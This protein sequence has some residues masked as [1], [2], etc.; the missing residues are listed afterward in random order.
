MPGPEHEPNALPPELA[1]F[2]KDRP[3]ACLLQPTDQGTIMVVKLPQRDIQTLSGRVPMR[4]RHEIYTHPQAPV[5]RVVVTIYDR[6]Q[7]PLALETFINIEDPQQR[8]DYSAL[9]N[10]EHLY[11]LFYD[12]QIQYRLGKGVD[13]DA[14]SDTPMILAQA[15]AAVAAIPPGRFDFD[16]AKAAVMDKTKL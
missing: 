10:Q 1:D 6:P 9:S 12:E 8:A 14:R 3:I 7:N 5:I 4:V 16:L 15:D 11:L 13:N 2:L